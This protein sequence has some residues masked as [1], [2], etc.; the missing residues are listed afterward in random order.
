MTQARLLLVEDDAS[1]GETLQERLVREGYSVE[2]VATQAD[3]ERQ[4]RAGKFDLII[5]DVGLPDGNGFDFARIV[6]RE[7]KTPFLFVT[8]MNGAEARLEGYE[9]GAEEFIPKPFHLKEALLRVRH[10]LAT[11]AEQA[12]AASGSVAARET[13]GVGERLEVGDGTVIEFVSRRVLRHDGSSEFLPGREFD[14][15]RLLVRKSP[16]VASRD[17][18]LNEVWGED[19]FPSHRTVDNAILRLRQILGEK[20]GGRIRSVRG[21]GYQWL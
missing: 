9:I 15:L 12:L 14:L 18:I 19:K 2:W 6:A 17:E 4:W 11:H 8:A 10:V 1:L 16:A 13:P 21:V 5:L 3:A 20:G 7:S